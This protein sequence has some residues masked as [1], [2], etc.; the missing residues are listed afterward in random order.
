MAKF[1]EQTLSQQKIIMLNIWKRKPKIYKQ[2][3]VLISV[4]MYFRPQ[5]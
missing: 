3:G 2:T 5:S 1:D 4:L